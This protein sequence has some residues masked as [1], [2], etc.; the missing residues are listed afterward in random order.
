MSLDN[1]R[2]EGAVIAVATQLD[3]D[4]VIIMLQG[5]KLSIH[6]AQLRARFVAYTLEKKVAR[7]PRQFGHGDIRGVAAPE[8][9]FRH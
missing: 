8:A 4:F 3:R 7:P 2:I 9:A 1:R 6:A 5:F